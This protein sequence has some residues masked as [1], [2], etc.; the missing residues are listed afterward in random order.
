[1]ASHFRPFDLGR[2]YILGFYDG[3]L[4]SQTVVSV[5]APCTSSRGHLALV[6]VYSRNIQAV[7]QVCQFELGL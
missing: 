7:E 5:Y 2:C 3:H 4:P 6:L 1:M